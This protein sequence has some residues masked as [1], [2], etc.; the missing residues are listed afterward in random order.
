MRWQADVIRE[1]GFYLE[2][3]A[4]RHEFAQ[5]I[6]ETR[7][8]RQQ[9]ESRNKRIGQLWVGAAIAIVGAIAGSWTGIAQW[10]GRHLPFALGNGGS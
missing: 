5:Q 10:I 1:A 7:E 6:R 8:R 9:K 4:D 2:N 3:P